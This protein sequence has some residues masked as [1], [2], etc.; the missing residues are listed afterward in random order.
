MN[1]AAEIIAL[2]LKACCEVKGVEYFINDEEEKIYF[3]L[4][5]RDGD[6]FEVFATFVDVRTTSYE[7]IVKGLY[8]EFLSYV[9]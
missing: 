3:N 6:M 2:K 1:Q 4:I 5:D 8:I 7:N 9:Y